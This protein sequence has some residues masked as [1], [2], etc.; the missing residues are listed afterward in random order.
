MFNNVTTFH[1]STQRLRRTDQLEKRYRPH[2]L[3]DI[4]IDRKPLPKHTQQVCVSG[5]TR[6][7]T[8]LT[9]QL[10]ALIKRN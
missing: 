9:V 7:R 3:L 5:E 8:S 6:V 1:L 4:L 2:R 10:N